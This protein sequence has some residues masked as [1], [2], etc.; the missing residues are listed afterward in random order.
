MDDGD[1]EGRA[2]S[3]WRMWRARVGTSDDEDEARDV[4]TE[5]WT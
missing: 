5:T 4:W 2:S 3:S 1:D